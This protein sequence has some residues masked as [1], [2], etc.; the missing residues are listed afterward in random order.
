MLD[1]VPGGLSAQML[2]AFDA[3]LAE[4][5]R[6]YGG[7]TAGTQSTAVKSNFQLSENSV[8]AA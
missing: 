5:P 4:V 7:T 1:Y 8:E 6:G 2:T 3:R